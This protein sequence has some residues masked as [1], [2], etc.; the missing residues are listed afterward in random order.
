MSG[1]DLSKSAEKKRPKKRP[2]MLCIWNGGAPCVYEGC[3]LWRTDLQVCMKV[4]EVEART[5]FFARAAGIADIVGSVAIHFA[6]PEKIREIMKAAGMDMPD[7]FEDG[8]ELEEEGESGED[9]G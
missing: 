2:K 3:P 9:R 8:E 1:F 4:T 5:D 6:S 7:G